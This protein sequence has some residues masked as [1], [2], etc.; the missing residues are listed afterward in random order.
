MHEPA[1]AGRSRRLAGCHSIAD[2]RRVARRRIPRPMFDYI[3]GGADDEV[4]LSHNSAAFRR[5]QILPRAL[6]D[7]AEVMLETTVL[8]TRVA[9][10]VV[11][12]PTGLTRLFH[13]EGEAAVARAAAAAGTIYSLSSMSSLSIEEVGRVGDGPKWFQIY[14][15]RDRGILREFIAR[16]RE[17]GYRALVLTVDVPT[18]GKRERDLRNGMTVPPRLTARSLL[19]VALRPH[20]VWRFLTSPP[21]TYANVAG[22]P[23]RAAGLDTL[24]AY[25]NELF[26]P[27][28]TWEDLAWMLEQWRGPFAVKGI[29]RAEDAARAASLGVGAIIV[30]NHGGRQ[31][32]HTPAPLEVLPDIVDA[33]DGRAEVILDGGVRRGTDVFKALALGARAC[34]IGR[35]YLYGLAAGGEPGVARALDLL[36]DE[37]ARALQL[38]GVRRPGEIDPGCLRRIG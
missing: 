7:V 20:W 28:V 38:A 35:P 32:D 13:H 23:G 15:W 6:V 9:L 26:D 19:D 21:I 2:L 14:V 37:L 34:M 30:S 22:R 5:W 31:L 8:G 10:P 3:D 29:L 25:V 36:R 12:A 1:T 18:F 24:T 11:L 17:A 4:T 16:A 33:V 27:S